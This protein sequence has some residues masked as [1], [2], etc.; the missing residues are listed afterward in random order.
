MSGKPLEH[1]KMVAEALL[2]S[3][4]PED[5]FE[6]VAFANDVRPLVPV[7]TKAGEENLEKAIATLNRLTAG[8]GTEMTH[9]MLKALEPLRPESQ[10]QVILLSDGQVGFESEVIG[11]LLER[12][13][14]GARLHA[15]AIG[16]APSRTL[17]RG[18]ARAGRG[19]E[20]LVGNGD[21][22]KVASRRLLQATVRPILTDIEVAGSALAGL[23][24]GRPQDV[25]AGQPLVLL[26]EIS[27]AG[28]ELERDA[29]VP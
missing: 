15:V 24:P 10:R 14:P 5:R 20:I 11:A 18:V 6:I 12:L 25:L 19:I 7:P 22:V 9:A 8:G 4:D 21:D 17:T 23:A 28:G 29:G 27:A 13:V 26:A 16:S 3:L 2:R 1:A